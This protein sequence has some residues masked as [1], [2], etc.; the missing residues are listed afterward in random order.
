MSDSEKERLKGFKRVAKENREKRRKAY[1]SFSTL[2]LSEGM[3]PEAAKGVICERFGLT[4]LQFNNVLSL[5]V[6]LDPSTV[7]DMD[8]T[9]QRFIGKGK[10]AVDAA[11][12]NLDE[13]LEKLDL[14][15]EAGLD[16]VVT[17][18]EETTGERGTTVKLKKQPINE[19]RMRLMEKKLEVAGKFMDRLASI[20]GRE[21]MAAAI[22]KTKVVVNIDAT[23]EFRAEFARMRGLGNEKVVVVDVDTVTDGS[24][25]NGE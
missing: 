3:D 12:E 13:E 19:A 10:G 8:A 22:G 17:E 24:V 5:R 9:I 11:W 6:D 2:V 21:A 7:V 18:A 1:H 23:E 15:E 4:A 16:G 25:G 20:A 14:M